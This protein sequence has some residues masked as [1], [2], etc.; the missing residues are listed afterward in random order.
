M[1]TFSALPALCAGNSPVTGEFPS[2]SPVTRR[3]DV[4]FDLRLNKRLSKQSRCRSFETPLCSLWRHC[5]VY[6]VDNGLN[7][8]LMWRSK[9]Q[10]CSGIG[11]HFLLLKS[12]SWNN[13]FSK[14]ENGSPMAGLE[15][16]TFQLYALCFNQYCS[17]VS[18]DEVKV[19]VKNAKCARNVH[20]SSFL[21]S[22]SLISAYY[23]KPTWLLDYCR[24]PKWRHWMNAIPRDHH[25]S[26]VKWA[27]RQL[28]SPAVHCFFKR[29]M[30]LERKTQ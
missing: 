19:H 16:M 14:M 21:L 24:V 30:W 3:F 13:H 9:Y 1:E 22:I 28:I 18:T 20:L 25:Y 15:P 10:P 27:F 23:C 29:L 4:F 6:F 17:Y 26:H 5:N 11:T 2:Q 8:H 7:V 12:C